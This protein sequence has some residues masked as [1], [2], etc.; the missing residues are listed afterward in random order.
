MRNTGARAWITVGISSIA[1]I[2][3]VA[4]SYELYR[5]GMNVPTDPGQQT[6]GVVFKGCAP[7]DGAAVRISLP[8]DPR[9]AYPL[10]SVG[11]WR[12]DLPQ[13]FAFDEN[14]NHGSSES[15]KGV[16]SYCPREAACEPVKTARFT[17]D[18]SREGVTGTYEATLSGGNT[19]QGSF[20]AEWEERIVLCG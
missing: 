6:G 15:G 1:F 9:H 20:T 13:S 14:V 16:V 10:I 4:L 7:W 3:L 18:D 11:I 12:D 2:A 8:L 17:F 19:V 5:H